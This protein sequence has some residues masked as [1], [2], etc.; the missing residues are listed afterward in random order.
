[1]ATHPSLTPAPTEVL[2]RPTEVVTED[3]D[4]DKMAHIV[5]PKEKILEAAVT[6][7]PC[8][9]LCGKAWVPNA[10]PDRYG[11]CPTCIEIFEEVMGRPWPGRR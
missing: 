2:D 6:G 9:A 8:F 10:N 1:M 5:Y 3:G 11:V 4:H 7:A